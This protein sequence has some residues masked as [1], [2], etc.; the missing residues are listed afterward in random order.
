MAQRAWW[1]HLLLDA[2]LFSSL[3]TWMAE[4]I[5]PSTGPDAARFSCYKITQQN[6]ETRYVRYFVPLE[7][8]EERGRYYSSRLP[9]HGTVPD[10]CTPVYR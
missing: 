2:S 9:V 4:D 1:A 8:R 10:E 7:Q 3:I 5:R 6:T